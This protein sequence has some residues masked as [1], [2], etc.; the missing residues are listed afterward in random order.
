MQSST[1]S[2]VGCLLYTLARP[3]CNL[4]IGR[5][6][7]RTSNVCSIV[8]DM[9]TPLAESLRSTHHP[10][11]RYQSPLGYFESIALRLIS[12][13][14]DKTSVDPPSFHLDLP[15]CFS[16]CWAC[17]IAHYSYLSW[18]EANTSTRKSLTYSRGA[19]TS[20]TT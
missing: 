12:F 10:I 18:V 6:M 3:P 5:E 15:N 7:E 20:C 13:P 19:Y 4:E 14:T 2:T 9:V 8:L 17:S 16:P 1:H 11:L